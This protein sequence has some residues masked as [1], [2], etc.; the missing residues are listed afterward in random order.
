MKKPDVLEFAQ[1][2]EEQLHRLWND[3]ECGTYRHEPYTTFQI[4]DPK[5]RTI[6][7]ACVRDRILHQALFTNLEPIF[8]RGF[9]FDSYSSR[10]GKGMLAMV[11]RFED[12]ARR[13]SGG[14]RRAVWILKCD[15]RKFFDSVDHARLKS[16]LAGKVSSLEALCL[17]SNIIESFSTRPGK[18]I[19]LGNITSQL[20][21]NVYLNPLDQFMKRRMRVGYYLRYAD[22]IMILADNKS[23]LLGHLESMCAF[24]REHLDLEIHPHK[25]SIRTWRQGVD[26]LG[27]VSYPNYRAIR[28]ITKWRIRHMIR[29]KRWMMREGLMDPDKFRETIASYRGRIK[30]AWSQK[31]S[32][33]LGLNDT[34]PNPL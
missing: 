7:K 20:F 28:T 26:V 3:I 32:E 9:I 25:I 29:A 23:E 11:K 13:I 4:R 31:L 12:F 33:F 6:N 14:D 18:G 1:N 15:I 2:A 27:Y 19:P 22:D 8:D 34:P 17:L 21:S 10:N 24:L 30:H 16:F 5:L